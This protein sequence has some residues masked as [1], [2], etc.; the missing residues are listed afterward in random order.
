MLKQTILLPIV[1]QHPNL[2]CLKSRLASSASMHW[3][4][5]P[6][7]LGPTLHPQSEATST[8]TPMN[9]HPQPWPGEWKPCM[10]RSNA[11]EIC[12]GWE[13]LSN[14]HPG[15]A[16]LGHG[17]QNGTTVHPS[18]GIQPRTVVPSVCSGAGTNLITSR[19]LA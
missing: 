12:R 2:Q 3:T 9:S 17:L 7:F 1:L 8:Q 14:P 10:T 15:S 6:R 19:I 18:S 4:T 11:A 16:N 5:K 13:C